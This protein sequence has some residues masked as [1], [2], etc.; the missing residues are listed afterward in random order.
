MK[1][2][3]LVLTLASTLAFLLTA[4]TGPALAPTALNQAS[5]VQVQRLG[6]ARQF[7]SA[8]SGFPI[9]LQ[10]V[11]KLDPTAQL[12]EIDI[13]QEPSGKSLQYGFLPSVPGKGPALRVFI[14]VESQVV[15]VE[16]SAQGTQTQLVNRDYWKLDSE[17]IYALAQ[18]NG[19]QDDTYLATLWEDTWHISGLKQHLYFQM[20]A[21]NGAIRLRCIGPYLDNCTTGDGN[22]VKTQSSRGMS[23]HLQ[24]RQT[25][26]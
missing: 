21:Q 6:K 26:R 2:T 20:D 7:N 17:A 13:W 15:R 19:L 4:C 12:Y 14:D 24:A 18:S 1:K 8:Q 11:Q 3:T 9:A 10:A 22:P 23:A 25:R 16:E 5:S